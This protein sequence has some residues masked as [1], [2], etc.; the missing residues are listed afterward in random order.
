M[1]DSQARNFSVVTGGA[2]SLFDG[3]QDLF[4]TGRFDGGG[5]KV[6][7]L[8]R[9]IVSEEEKLGKLGALLLLLANLLGETGVDLAKLSNGGAVLF[10]VSVLRC[11]VN[12][13]PPSTQLFGA[14]PIVLSME[15]ALVAL[16][17]LASLFQILVMLL[18]TIVA[19]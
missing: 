2:P 8:L 12:G 18:G 10:H 5:A 1:A 17:V 6:V 14:L 16:T 15:V 11:A 13:R 19:D 3:G 9:Q 4:T 7:Q